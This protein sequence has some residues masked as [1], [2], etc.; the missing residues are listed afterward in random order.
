MADFTEVADRVW[1]TRLDW[2]DVN[3]TVVGGADGLAVVDTWASAD[4]ARGLLE[5][6]RRLGGPVRFA[7]NTHQHVDHTFGNGVFAAAGAELVAH[8]DV[9]L[10][11][12]AHAEEVRRAAAAEHPGD[13]RWAGL[14][15]TETVVPTRTF[16]SVTL[17]HL[18]DRALEVLHPGRGHTGGDCVVHVP[19]AEVVVAGDLVEQAGGGVPA[20]GEDCW[21]LAWAETLDVVIGLLRTTTT[22]VPGHGS[23]VDRE[24]VEEQRNQIGLVAG[25]IG[26]LAGQG[27]PAEAALEGDA[28]WPYPKEQLVH[29][30]RRGYQQLPR[31]ARQLPLA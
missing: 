8:E 9:P 31:G 29:A 3:V 18:G 4:L 30:V 2:F 27:V 10:T 21:P 7:V 23:C 14:V 5:D 17:L 24:F 25:M 11:L 15:A 22:V 13:A 19:D 12:P 1:V 16:S 6:V 28:E 26:Q 20:F